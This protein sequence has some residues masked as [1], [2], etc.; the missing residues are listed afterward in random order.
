MST[1]PILYPRFR[2]RDEESGTEH[3]LLL[4]C[5]SVLWVSSLWRFK[6]MPETDQI[7]L[8]R[9]NFRTNWLQLMTT[10]KSGRCNDT[11]I[12]FWM[13]SK[14]SS[15]S[16]FQIMKSTFSVQYVILLLP[17][18]TH[19]RY[20]DQEFG[21]LGLFF[22]LHGTKCTNPSSFQSHTDTD[23]LIYACKHCYDLHE[24]KYQTN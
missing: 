17:L 14:Q 19:Y 1:F 7:W 20:D 22:L 11:I 4:K 9:S 15:Y 24:L 21:M 23:V 2:I 18:F 10:S 8:L 13:S 16:V 12:I 5:D 3:G 6:Q